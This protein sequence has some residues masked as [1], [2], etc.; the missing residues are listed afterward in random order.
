MT[1]PNHPTAAMNASWEHY[2]TAESQARSDYLAAVD[3]AQRYFDD[4]VRPALDKYH[5]HERAAWTAYTAASRAAKRAYLNVVGP[6][7][8]AAVAQM[9]PAPDPTVAYAKPNGGD[10]TYVH[11]TFTPH[12]EGNQ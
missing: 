8:D 5:A 3:T 11:P 1:T 10:V 4:E 6:V 12:Q 7:A 2:R 9:L